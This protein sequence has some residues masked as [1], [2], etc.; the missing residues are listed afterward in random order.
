M[1]RTSW[2]GSSLPKISSFILICTFDLHLL[3][4][5]LFTCLIDDVAY[6]PVTNLMSSFISHFLPRR[7]E[8]IGFSI[9]FNFFLLLSFQS[10][11][12][13]LFWL[14]FGQASVLTYDFVV[15]LYVEKTIFFSLACTDNHIS[16]AVWKQYCSYHNYVI[17]NCKK[18]CGTCTDGESGV[19]TTASTG[20]NG[21]NNGM[22]LFILFTITN[23]LY[24][25]RNIEAFKVC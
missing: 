24:H 17:E 7:E 9:S 14:M 21:G 18:T 1:K 19:T 5:R 8:P 15:Y 4:S 2:R 11:L 6:F 3:R 12:P 22:W 10:N 23:P 16:C 13:Y 25:Y 20:G